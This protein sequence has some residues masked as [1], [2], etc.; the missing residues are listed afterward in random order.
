M[1]PP[2]GLSSSQAVSN[3][4]WWTIYKSNVSP[5]WGLWLAL[6]LVWGN[7]PSS[8][9]MLTK[10]KKKNLSFSFV[11]FHNE[12]HL[13][14]IF[15]PYRQITLKSNF[16]YFLSALCFLGHVLWLESSI[17]LCSEILYLTTTDTK[18]LLVF[19]AIPGGI[20]CLKVQ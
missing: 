10:K 12:L 5:L 6:A 4:P 15:L 2:K 8:K 14:F 18:I 16:V 9:L 17:S 7:L 1:L 3:L 11:K 13:N 20:D 19:Q